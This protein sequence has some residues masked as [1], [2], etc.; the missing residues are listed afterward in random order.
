MIRHLIAII[1]C[2][3]LAPIAVAANHQTVWSA[4]GVGANGGTMAQ[5]T[6]TIEPSLMQGKKGYDKHALLALTGKKWSGRILCWT[7]WN[8]KKAGFQPRQYPFI[9]L[10]ARATKPAKYHGITMALLRKDGDQT[11]FVNLAKYDPKNHLQKAKTYVP[12][13]IP[14]KDFGANEDDQIIGVHFGM[15][16]LDKAKDEQLIILEIRAAKKP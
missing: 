16:S 8:P 4:S 7:D 11:S 12:L 14:L 2:L 1:C 13:T 9:Q 6:W 3:A 10:I 15:E 5:A